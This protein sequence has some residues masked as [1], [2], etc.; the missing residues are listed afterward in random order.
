MPKHSFN[1]LTFN[2]PKSNQ[3]FYFTNSEQPNL[4]R[5]Y[6]TLVPDEV[7][8]KY[9]EQEHYY[10]SFAQN[11]N[12][13]LSVTKPT[14]PTF[15]KKKNKAGENKLASVHNSA[16]SSSVLKRYYNSLIHNHFKGKGYLVKPNFIND[17]EVWLPSESQDKTGQYKIFDRYSLKVQFRTVTENLELLVTFEGRSKIFKIPVSS[18]LEDVSPDD[19]NWVVFEKSLYHFDELPDAGKR[20]YDAVYP[21]WN[22]DIRDALQQE[23]EAPDKSNKYRKFKTAINNFYNTHLNTKEFKDIIPLSSEGFISVNEIKIGSVS[24]N[25]NRLLFGEEKSGIVPMTGI[26]DH[27]PFD[28]SPS[29]KIHFF[30]IMHEDDKGAAETIHKFFK[31]SLSGFKGLTKFIHTPYY[32]NKELALIFKNGEDPWPEIYQGITDKPFE[33]DIQYMAIYLSP[34]SKN[35]S[36]RSRRKLY[37]KIKELLLKKGI[38]SQVI[39]ADKVLTNEKYHYSLPNISIAILAKLNGIPWKLDTK[40]KNELIVGVG[41]FRNTE[42]DVQYIGSAFSFANNGKFNR[43]EYFQDNQIN[44]LAGSILRAVKEYANVNSGIKRLVIHFYKSM[45]QDELQ[46]IEDGL[47]D[48]GLDIPVFIVS[49]NKTESCDIIAFDEEWKDLM[50]VSG[51]YINVGYNKFLLFNNTRYGDENFNFNDGYPFPIKLKIYCTEKELVDDFKTVKELIDQVYQFSRMYWKS[52]R[53][54]NLPVT[55]KYPEMIAEIVPHFEGTDISGF[56]E[57]NLWFL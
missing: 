32:A 33:S 22:F 57:N 53:Q 46:P 28:L 11:L 39:E 23:T 36:D 51:T 49:I 18:M 27:G 19:F 55:I 4:T 43:F 20:K 6:K 26:R 5:I 7:I 10:T 24:K 52:V 48:L 16:F 8:E 13:Y 34:Y 37:Y 12:G 21:V 54:Q 47:K 41:A 35:I 30:F 9:G 31:G 25:S 50:P 44:E 1:I 17:T 56:S 15:E 42:V 3:T 45:S 40:L 14:T 38:P 2:H 29:S